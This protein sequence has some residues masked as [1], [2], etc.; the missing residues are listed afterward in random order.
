MADRKLSV[1][2]ADVHSEDWVNFNAGCVGFYR[3][4][5]PK[6]L[7]DR[8]VPAIVDMTL[9]KNDRLNLIS[10]QTALAAAGYISAA[11]LLQFLEHFRG[12]KECLVWEAIGNS[13]WKV[14]FILRE[15]AAAT[16][17]FNQWVRW[18]FGPTADALGWAAGADGGEG[19][20][21]GKFRAIVQEH[22]VGAKD[23][24]A[25]RQGR[26]LFAKHCDGAGAVPPDLQR[27]AYTAAVSAD[28]AKALE[29]LMRLATE[30]DVNE[31]QVRVYESLGGGTEDPDLLQRVIDFGMSA[32][33]RYQGRRAVPS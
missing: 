31:E 32:S 9:P 30:T 18:L 13:L 1:D 5:Y 2:L 21:A 22:M 12:E 10:D 6:A 3:V 7:L 25:I 14:H 26:D 4:K 23:E 24:R 20:M 16:E 28:G 17:T 11:D 8:F 33:V 15:D 29:K 19:Y 27:A